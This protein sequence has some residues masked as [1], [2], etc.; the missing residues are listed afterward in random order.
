MKTIIFAA[1]NPKRLWTLNGKVISKQFIKLFNNKSLF[2]NLVEKLSKF[3]ELDELIIF[4]NSDNKN[5]I[6]SQLKDI[7]VI[8]SESNMFFLSINDIYDNF[9]NIVNEIDKKNISDVVMFHSAFLYDFD[10]QAN[11]SLQK[12]ISDNI[13]DVENSIVVFEKSGV[14]INKEIGVVLFDTAA[15]LSQI[16]KSDYKKYKVDCDEKNEYIDYFNEILCFLDYFNKK[17]VP[18]V[19]DYWSRLLGL[20]TIY[21]NFTGKMPVGY[22]NPVFKRPWGEYMVFEEGRYFKIKQI[23]VIP[24]KRLSLQKHK[25]RNENWLIL[26]GKAIVTKGKNEIS[27]I[28]G[29]TCFIPVNTVHRVEN[30]EKEPL[31]IL[32]V[33]TGEYFGEDD[34]ERLADDFG[35]ETNN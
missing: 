12:M 32:E 2:Q 28:A 10:L 5:K 26:E 13:N 17:S 21:N 8:L 35:R 3:T 14:K 11:N 29:E 25:L 6:L 18:L 9:I 4:S 24:G 27:L 15:I 22:S 31:I 16:N 20:D 7:N 1:E 19:T 23:M 33:Q 34:I 30:R